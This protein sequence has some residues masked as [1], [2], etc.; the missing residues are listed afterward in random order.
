M[1]KNPIQPTDYNIS[2]LIKFAIVRGID[3]TSSDEKEWKMIGRALKRLGMDKTSFVALSSIHDGSTKNQRAAAYAWE[4]AHGN[5]YSEEAAAQ[6]ILYF[7]SQAGIKI[8]DFLPLEKQEEIKKYLKEKQENEPRRRRE[9]FHRLI[10]GSTQAEAPKPTDEATEQ[11]RIIEYLPTSMLAQVESLTKQT[12]LYRFML[13]EFGEVVKP[14]FAAYHVGGC[15]KWRKQQHGLATAFPIIDHNGNIVDMQLSAFNPDGHG[16]KK[17]NGDKVKNYA[18]ATMGKSDRRADWCMF[19]SHLLNSNP[20]LPIAIVEAPKT[21]LIGA[22]VYPQYLWLACF[23]RN[24]L[25]SAVSCEPFKGREVWLFPDREQESITAWKKIA[26]ELNLI[27][28]NVQVSNYL[29]H[30]PG[31]PHD[32]LADIV[33]R[34]RHG[35]QKPPKGVPTTDTPRLSPDRAEAMRVFEDMKKRYPPLA[36]LAELLQLEPISVEPYHCNPKEDE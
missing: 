17:D 7:A 6:K 33:L 21:A 14:I 35:G 9:Y 25:N 31:F 4:H 5:Y 1:E 18:L 29:E 36:R 34:Y 12:T 13:A 26:S 10:Y 30:F 3:I 16:T 11:P 27:G 24:W 32:D 15:A 19:G 2:E 22:L 23:S 8:Y 20:N 28:Y